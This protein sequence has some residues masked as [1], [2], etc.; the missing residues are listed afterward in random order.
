MK[1]VNTVDCDKNI[2]HFV[3]PTGAAKR[4]LS[5]EEGPYEIKYRYCVINGAEWAY[6]YKDKKFVWDCNATF[7]ECHFRSVE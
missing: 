4:Y 6:L 7:A 1:A 5:E 3:I 2:P